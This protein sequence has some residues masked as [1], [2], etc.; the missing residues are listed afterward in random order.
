M[1]DVIVMGGGVIGQ[2]VAYYL[3]Q[4]G[5]RTLLL[6]RRDVGRATAAGAGCLISIPC[7]G[8]IAGKPA[9]QVLHW[10][11]NLQ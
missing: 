3:T 8:T 10:L 2:A 9:L 11:A 6:D 1:H 7:C 5:A 4:A